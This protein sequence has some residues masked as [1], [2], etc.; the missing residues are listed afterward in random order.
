MNNFKS[1]MFTVGYVVML[2]GVACRVFEDDPDSVSYCRYI[3]VAGVALTTVFRLL[4]LPKSD[5]RRVRHLNMQQ[6]FCACF[7]CLGAFM[8][9]KGYSSWVLPFLISALADI[10]LSY[11]YGRLEK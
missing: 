2:V 7:Q 3:V 4:S 11:A 8:V 10:A 5:D 9:W 6:L 1:I